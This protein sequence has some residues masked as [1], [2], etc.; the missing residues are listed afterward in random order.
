MKWVGTESPARTVPTS[1]SCLKRSFADAVSSFAATKPVPASVTSAPL[2]SGE[3]SARLW[4]KEE[5]LG[6]VDADGEG[7]KLPDRMKRWW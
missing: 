3:L 1:L 6:Q 4:S 5:T 7:V 2:L